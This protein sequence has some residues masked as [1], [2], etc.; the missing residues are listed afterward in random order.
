MPLAAVL[1]GFAVQ[2]NPK[3]VDMR[4]FIIIACLLN[5]L[6][7]I[8]SGPSLLLPDSWVL[9]ALGNFILGFAICY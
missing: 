1:A 4:V 6:G 2:Y 3:H 9:I 7:F 5:I 8:L